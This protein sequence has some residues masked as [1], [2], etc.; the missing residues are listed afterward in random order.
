VRPWLK[1]KKRRRRRERGGGGREGEEEEGR[2]EEEVREEEEEKEE[3]KPQG[4]GSTRNLIFQTRIT[5]IWSRF[6]LIRYNYP[7]YSLS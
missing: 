3:R 6:G 1:K 7:K 5:D 4:R 2:E